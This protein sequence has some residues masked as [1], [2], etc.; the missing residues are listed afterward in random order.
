[1]SRAS[2]VSLLNQRLTLIPSVILPD[3]ICYP[4]LWHLD[5]SL[6]NILVAPTGPANILGLIDWQGTCIM[7]YFMQANF[8]SAFAYTAGLIEMPSGPLPTLPADIEHCDKAEQNTLCLH[9]CL[10]L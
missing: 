10:A 3:D 5:L 8:P 4:T 9:Y 1:M 7:S 2:L 6:S